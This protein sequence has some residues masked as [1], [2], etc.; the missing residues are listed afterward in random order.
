MC[1]KFEVVRGPVGVA[2][3]GGQPESA[4]KPN[5]AKPKMCGALP[6]NRHKPSPI[7]LRRS[8]GV[9]TTIHNF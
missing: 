9:P 4:P 7:D 6:T 1:L 2:W 5:E 8:R 3:C